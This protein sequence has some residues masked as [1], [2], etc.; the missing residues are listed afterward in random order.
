ME[1]NW[2][3]KFLRG[4][5]CSVSEGYAEMRNA[6]GLTGF[7]LIAFRLGDCTDGHLPIDAAFCLLFPCI[8]SLF[9]RYF[10]IRPLC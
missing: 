8:Y 10:D 1:H 4:I 3:A 5:S 6:K 9:V 7:G 2:N